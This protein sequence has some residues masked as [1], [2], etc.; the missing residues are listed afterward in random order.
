I[1][2]GVLSVANAALRV[3]FPGNSFIIG[4]QIT[5]IVFGIIQTI[6]AILVFVACH[7]TKS[8]L[9]I[10]M[11]V[12]CIVSLVVEALMVIACVVSII[13]EDAKRDTFINAA[14]TWAISFLITSFLYYVYRKCYK[15]LKDIEISRDFVDINER[16]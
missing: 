5:A 7:K 16:A 15:Y 10:P 11:L 12:F 3:H 2:I 4:E 6:F 1:V 8:A 13:T 9:M 14:V